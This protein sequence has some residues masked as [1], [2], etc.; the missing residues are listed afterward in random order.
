MGKGLDL[1]IR[2][3][4]NDYWVR[5]ITSNKNGEIIYE[6]YLM[7]EPISKMKDYDI[8]DGNA[9]GFKLE[10]EEYESILGDMEKCD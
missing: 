3:L 5:K 9:I 8:V 1:V 7:V 4:T 10:K 2:K 6:Y